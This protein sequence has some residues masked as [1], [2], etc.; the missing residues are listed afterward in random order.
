M[1]PSSHVPSIR[2]SGLRSRAFRLL[3]S[4][5]VAITVLGGGS[6]VATSTAALATSTVPANVHRI[7]GAS[8]LATAIAT[9]QDQFAATGSAQAVVLTRSDT[10]PDA[11]AGV[12]LA[13]KVG[14]P[15]LLTGSAALDPAVKAEI[16]RVLPAGATV[17]ILGGTV[18]VSTAVETTI[19]GLGFVVKRIAGTDRFATAVAVADALGD[20][21]TVFEATGLNFPDALAGGPAA[22][23]KGGAILLTNGSTQSPA[24]AAYLV[25]HPGGTHYAL[26]GPAAA[27]DPTATALSGDDRYWTAAAVAF[28]F[29]ADATTVG[30]ATGGNFP[31]AL[32]AGP[33]LAAKGAPLLLVPTA[34]ALPEGVAVDLLAR[35]FTGST[36]VVLFGGTASVSDDVA[37]QLGV[38]GGETGAAATASTAA[39]NTGQFGVIS[40]QLNANGLVG[41][42]TLAVD[43]AS[44]DITVYRQAGTTLTDTG[45]ARADFGALPLTDPDALEAAVNSMFAT[46]DSAAGVTGDAEEL[47]TL[48]AE[49]VIL[50]PVASPSLRLAIYAA[51]AADDSATEVAAGVKDSTGRVGI[52][53]FA[54]T[55]ATATDKGKISY[56]FDPVTLQPLEDSVIGPTG[57]VI[58][59]QTIL[60][61]T[62]S[63][64][65]PADPYTP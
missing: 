60:S 5:V 61:L 19:T 36:H 22:I 12:P 53:I 52:E 48:N 25:A 24:T 27:A 1:I 8:R 33:D 16:V 26:G 32:A 39:A 43:G 2:R 13:A 45:P 42:Q 4:G 20:P 14:G 23:A 38:L 18:A 46:F 56:I 9:S 51:L 28:T 21:T 3:G 65:L 57:S 55:G 47:F 40:E 30:A 59:R 63:A 50:N 15:L 37:S 35:T 58:E 10:Y 44:G 11:L 64:T 41:K 34:G 17:Y 7:A 49:Q 31:D 54:S 6:V 62:T 29:F